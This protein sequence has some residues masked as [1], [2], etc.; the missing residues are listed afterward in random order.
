[1]VFLLN[2]YVA[3]PV[4]SSPSSLV[5]QMEECGT[6]HIEFLG[7]FQFQTGIYVVLLQDNFQ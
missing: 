2:Q 1:M 7:F 4:R 6:Y 5:I 3:F